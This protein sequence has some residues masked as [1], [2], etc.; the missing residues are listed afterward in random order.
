MELNRVELALKEIYD[1]WQLGNECENNGYSAMFRMGYPDEYIDS[2]RPL[3]MYV[4]QEDLDG[5]PHKTQAW[6]RKYQIVQQTKIYNKEIARGTNTSPFWDF[7]RKLCDIGYN[8][9]WNNLDKFLYADHKTHLLT[10][11]AAILSAA[12]GLDRLSVLQREIKQLKPSVIV[13]AI[14][15][16]KKYWVSLASAF[17]LNEKTLWEHKPTIKNCVNDISDILGLENTIVLWTYHPNYLRRRGLEIAVLN[18]IKQKIDT[19]RKK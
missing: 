5:K 2:D 14:G 10:E 12:Y 6:V 16:R 15:P 3:L 17:S 8:G 18:E 4:G 11:D 1:G 19:R 7:Y 9:L 13:F